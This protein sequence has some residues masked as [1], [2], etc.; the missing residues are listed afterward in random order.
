MIKFEW[1]E[2]KGIRFE[3]NDGSYDWYDP[4]S[5]VYQTNDNYEVTNYTN[6]NTYIIP[7][8]DVED[9]FIYTQGENDY[10]GINND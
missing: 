2:N 7:I 5:Y 4:V 3:Y 10:E 8:E 1:N 6:T 9:I